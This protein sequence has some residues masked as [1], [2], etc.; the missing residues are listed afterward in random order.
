MALPHRCRFLGLIALQAFVLTGCS[1]KEEAAD[2]PTPPQTTST[3]N[4]TPVTGDW[5]IQAISSDPDTLNPITNQDE[6]GNMIQSGNI[7]E[8]LLTMDNDT[9]RLKPLLAESYEISPD[10][11]TYTFHLRHDAKWQ[12]GKPMTADDVK[13]SF[14]RTMDPKVDAADKRSYLTTIKSCEILDPYTIRFTADKRYFKT[15]ESLG[16][17][18]IVP[19]HLLETGDF[20]ENP[21][22]RHPVGSGPYKFVRWDTGSQVVLERDDNYWAGPGHYPTR[23][24]YQ[25]IQEPYVTA[26]LL[27]KGEL[28]VVNG[29]TPIQW[30]R[31]L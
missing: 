11:L 5:V 8:G 20:N 31:E 23:L 6:T 13:F 28:D 12:D 25:I 26:Q 29:V 19:K 16:T 24:V 17:L 3:T 14:D 27:K 7:F 21:F 18:P 2:T 4:Q 30:E 9:L 22:G 15:L 1:K 10:Q